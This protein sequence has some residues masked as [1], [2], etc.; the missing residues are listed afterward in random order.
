MFYLSKDSELDTKTLTTIISHFATSVLP[1]LRRNKEYYDGIQAISGKQYADSNK[2]A[3]KAVTNFC[4][5]ITDSYCGYIASP[6]YISYRSRENIEQLMDILRYNDYQTEDADFLLNALIYGTAAEL[7]FTD[8]AAKVRFKLINPTQ[9]F[10]IYDNTLTEELLYFVRF[11]KENQWSD[12]DDYIVDVYNDSTIKHYKMIGIGGSI[13]FIDE[14]PHYFNQVPANIFSLADEKSVYDC[15]LSLQDAYNELLSDDIDDYAAFFDA[16]LALYGVDAE[17]EDIA[18]MKKNRVLVLPNDAKTEWVTK[19]LSD[20]QVENLLQ[21]VEKSIYKVAHCPDFSS[22]SFVN[23]VSSGIAIQY[24]LT[25][26]ETRAAKIVAEMKEALLHRVEII[27]GIA[28]LTIG[29]EVF[30]DVDIEFQRNI[31]VDTN[32]VVQMVN[33]L[34]GL[35]SDATLLGQIDFVSDVNAELEAV[36]EQNS[37]N[38]SLYDFVAAD[39]PDDDEKELD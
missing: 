34:R 16:Y 28:T 38:F 30:S 7:M 10:G 4:K 9:C 8:A 18:A 27:C 19:N 36:K 25:G 6:G 29:E 15:I 39:Y 2:K 33:S 5:D 14:E 21:R 3:V 13:E 1:T 17:E 31:P 11:Y 26:M 35:V 24:R 32:S 20:V 23:G 12:T 22:E 37:N